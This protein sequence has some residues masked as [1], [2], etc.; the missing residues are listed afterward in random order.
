VDHLEITERPVERG[1]LPPLLVRPRT[2][3]RLLGVGNT[4]GYELLK[5]GELLSFLDGRA[6]KITLESIHKY[7]ARKLASAGTGTQ[8][9][10]APALPC[11]SPPT[12]SADEPRAKSPRRRGRPGKKSDAAVVP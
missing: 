9:E 1:E 2:A 7:I 6:R 5:A 11:Q 8:P 10:A 3:W 12:K 4:R